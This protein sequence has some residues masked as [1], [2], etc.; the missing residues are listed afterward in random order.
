MTT[1]D[2]AHVIRDLWG[3]LDG[4][5]EPARWEEIR[6][7]LASCE[8]C[9]SHVAFCRAFLVQV[10]TAP[11]DPDEVARVRARIVALMQ[12]GEAGS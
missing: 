10:A 7:H 5:L 6:L 2:C 9:A 11:L 1:L 4:E 3:Y 12:A 8:G